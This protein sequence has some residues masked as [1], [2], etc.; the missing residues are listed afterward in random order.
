MK[1]VAKVRNL[2]ISKVFNTDANRVLLI[3]FKIMFTSR[4]SFKNNAAVSG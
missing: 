1:T 3:P 2:Q 4:Y